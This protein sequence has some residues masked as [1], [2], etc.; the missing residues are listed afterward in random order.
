MTA[1][2]KVDEIFA[3][4][5][6]EEQ[7]ADQVAAK[8]QESVAA[9]EKEKTEQAGV[10]VQEPEESV[11]GVQDQEVAVSVEDEKEPHFPILRDGDS[12]FRSIAILKHKELQVP[13]YNV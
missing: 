5:V 8:N 9:D 4:D 1:F 3:L 11:G 2:Y 7:K 13:I 12:L 10:E 6:G